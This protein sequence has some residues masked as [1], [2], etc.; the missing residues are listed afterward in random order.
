[1]KFIPLFEHI[2]VEPDQVTNEA[3]K[4]GNTTIYMPDRSMDEKIKAINKGKIVESASKLPHL[5]KGTVVVYYPFA[6][7]KI[8]ENEIEYHVIHERDVM[9]YMSEVS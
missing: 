7:N 6:A 1:M 8:K 3:K 4:V 9:G 5:E 2:K